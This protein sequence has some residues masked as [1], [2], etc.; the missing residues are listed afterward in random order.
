M[1][2]RSSRERGSFS[3]MCASSLCPE[4]TA[5][6]ASGLPSRISVA[7]LRGMPHPSHTLTGWTRAG[8]GLLALL[9][10]VGVPLEITLG[11]AEYPVVPPPRAATVLLAGSCMLLL[12]SGWGLRR[13]AAERGVAQTPTAGL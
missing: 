1:T 2:Q 11:L 3:V 5:V 13:L 9:A 8:V 6:K 4:A 10:C 12:W 7:T